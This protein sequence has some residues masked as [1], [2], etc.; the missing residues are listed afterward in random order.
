ML[1]QSKAVKRR[2]ATPTPVQAGAVAAAVFEHT[3]STAF[4]AASD[5][6]EIGA[7]P[8]TAQIIGATVIGSGMGAIT[9][10]IGLMT[11][12]AGEADETRTS[13]AEIFNDQSVNN[14]TAAA[15]LSTCLGI[16]KSEKHR[17]IG[18]TLSGNVAAGSAKLTLLIQ[19]VY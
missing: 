5:I 16:A 7:L 3:F 8:A 18:V 1:Q 14:T 17:G 9:A 11:G 10:D 19:Y 2:N 12:D 6:L 4:T 13:G 15:A